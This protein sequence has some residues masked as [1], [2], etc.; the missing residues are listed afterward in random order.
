M[1][2]SE[3]A[4]RLATRTGMNKVAGW[5]TVDGVFAA[6]GDAL[7]NGEEVSRN[8]R[9]AHGCPR[10]SYEASR[11]PPWRA[12]SDRAR[13]AAGRGWSCRRPNRGVRPHRRQPA[14]ETGESCCHCGCDAPGESAV[15][16]DDDRQRD[17][18][19]PVRQGRG[20][21]AVC[22]DWAQQEAETRGG[23]WPAA[24]ALQQPQERP[25]VGSGRD[26]VPTHA[27][28]GRVRRESG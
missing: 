8:T 1:N 12:G 17:P 23:V 7:A 9:R 4:G 22:A 6:I 13:C 10:A 15:P 26:S 18:G 19:H 27:R 21:L 2:E 20:D 3:M 11:R 14:Q 28:D 16:G 5:D 24:S 25:P